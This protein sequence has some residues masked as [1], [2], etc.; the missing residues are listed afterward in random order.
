M[1]SDITN[2]LNSSLCD[3]LAVWTCADGEHSLHIIGALQH[4]HFAA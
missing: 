4:T 2:V 3:F 1:G